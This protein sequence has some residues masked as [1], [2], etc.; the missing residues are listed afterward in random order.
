MRLRSDGVL[1]ACWIRTA[2]RPRTSRSILSSR[3]R[4]FVIG[5]PQGPFQKVIEVLDRHGMV[6]GDRLAPDVVLVSIGD[7]FDYDHDD[8]ATAGREGLRLLSW[9]ADHDPEQ[10]ILLLGN[11]D[12]AR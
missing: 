8:P 1:G 11:H 12:A 10:V 7:H 6:A 5:D 2:R 4:A 3:M 9:L